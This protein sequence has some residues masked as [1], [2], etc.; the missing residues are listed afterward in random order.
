MC[1]SNRARPWTPPPNNQDLSTHTSNAST[2][3]TSTPQLPTSGSVPLPR[4]MTE[5]GAATSSPSGE[6]SPKLVES[7]SSSFSI[8]SFG[9]SGGPQGNPGVAPSFASFTRP[10][11]ERSLLG[12]AG[13][14]QQAAALAH[15]GLLPPLIVAPSELP[16]LMVG[17]AQG[18]WHMDCFLLYAVVQTLL[19]VAVGV[20]CIVVGI[21][22]CRF[23]KVAIMHWAGAVSFRLGQCCT[24][25][26]TPVAPAQLVRM[27]GADAK[28]VSFD[29]APLTDAVANGCRSLHTAAAPSCARHPALPMLSTSG[30]PCPQ[31]SSHTCTKPSSRSSDE[32]VADSARLV[33]ASTLR[34]E[35]GDPGPTVYTSH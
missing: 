19:D 17:G 6:S 3:N 13:P 10:S 16:P 4:S 1:W 2:S 14:Q 34:A 9:R 27:G 23:V 30:P 21:I 8:F 7:S 24:L 32:L 28:L 18:W 26:A 29:T 25:T 15:A 22:R 5:E 35:R 33:T 20:W 12:R 31:T 11:P